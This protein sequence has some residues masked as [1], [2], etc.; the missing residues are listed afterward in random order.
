MIGHTKCAAGLAGLVNATLALHHKVLPPLLVEKPNSKAKF[1]DSP[2]FLNGEA[3]PWVHGGPE[4]RVAG[5]SAFGF[6]GT[7]FHAV[8]EE[9]TGDYLAE[10]HPAVSRWPAELLVWRRSSMESLAS[11]LETLRDALAAVPR[12]NSPTWHTPCVRRARCRRNSMV[13]A[14]VATSLDDLKQKLDPALTLLRSGQQHGHDPRGIFFA[15]GTRGRTL[16]APD[17]SPSSSPVRDR[18]IPTCSLSWRWCFRRCGRA[19]MPPRAALAGR[20]DRPLGKFI[21]PPSSFTPEQ[22][23]QAREALTRTDVAQPALG[24]ASLGMFRLLARLGVRADLFAGH[25]YG[26]YVALCA[27]GTLSTDDLIRV[28]HER[29]RIILDATERMPGAMAAVEADAETVAAVVG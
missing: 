29:G 1:E 25:S 20:L 15:A 28:S 8:L 26:D 17:K 5:V 11:A 10:T 24:A 23:K 22:E 13:L 3:R 12:P 27:A 19:S 18:S 7:N 6:G 9:Y 21:F 16:S 2:F 4:P 14:I